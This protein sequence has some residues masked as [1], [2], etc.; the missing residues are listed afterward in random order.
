MS[1]TPA[2]LS[3]TLLNTELFDQGLIDEMVSDVSPGLE[4]CNHL[5][6]VATSGDELHFCLLHNLDVAVSP[7]DIFISIKYVEQGEDCHWATHVQN[8]FGALSEFKPDLLKCMQA[9]NQLTII[10]AGAVAHLPAFKKHNK[11]ASKKAAN[12]KKAGVAYV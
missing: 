7:H 1:I 10:K 5:G 6:I 11:A 4:N 9:I 8:I 12:K 3:Q 2:L